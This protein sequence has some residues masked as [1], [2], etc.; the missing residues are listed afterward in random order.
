MAKGRDC[1]PALLLYNNIEDKEIIMNNTK[2]IDLLRKRNAQIQEELDRLKEINNKNAPSSDNK[3]I[4]HLIKE[5]EG[6]KEE[7]M[8][9]LDELNQEREQYRNLTEDLRNIRESFGNLI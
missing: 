7:W 3:K 2:T 9:I 5:L 1:S 6:I 8:T 4:S